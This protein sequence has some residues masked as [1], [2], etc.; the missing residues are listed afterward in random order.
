M[1]RQ[2]RERR[3]DLRALPPAAERRGE[4]QPVSRGGHANLRIRSANARSCSC[5]SM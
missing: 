4:W 1:P 2:A 5:R 3:A